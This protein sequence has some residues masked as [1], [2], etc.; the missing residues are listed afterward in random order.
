[1]STTTA[2]TIDASF[3]INRD[4]TALLVLLLVLLLLLFLLLLFC[5][6]LLCLVFA[7]TIIVTILSIIVIQR[8]AA[9]LGLRRSAHGDRTHRLVFCNVKEQGGCRS[10][11]EGGGGETLMLHIQV[12]VCFTYHL[13]VSMP[14][15]QGSS[16]VRTTAVRL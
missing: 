10:G 11:R 2:I 7:I 16:R 6:V 3:D 1:M 4:A 15:A 13:H 8:Y 5:L 9:R 12:S 14:V